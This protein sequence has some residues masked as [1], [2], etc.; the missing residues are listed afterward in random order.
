MIS[1][2]ALEEGCIAGVMRKQVMQ[3]L[4][5]NNITV[6]ETAVPVEELLNADEVFLS[7]SIFN[8][9]WVQSIGDKR[10]SNRVI[11]KIYSDI[12]STILQ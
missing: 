2:A 10:Y 7:N 5:E 12:F 6:Q 3:L 1:T 9:R 8:I 11:Q 4:A